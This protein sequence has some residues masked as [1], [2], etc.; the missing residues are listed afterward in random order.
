MYIAS[1]T[2][3]MDD[4][5]LDTYINYKTKVGVPTIVHQGSIQYTVM[6]NST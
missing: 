6:M 3:C 4:G 1:L 5:L 2:I